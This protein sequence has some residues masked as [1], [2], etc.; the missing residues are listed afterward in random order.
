MFSNEDALSK[1]DIKTL[2]LSRHKCY[3]LLRKYGVFVYFIHAEL[4]KQAPV[5]GNDI[6]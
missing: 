5:I 3:I 1:A 4:K 2:A 6:E